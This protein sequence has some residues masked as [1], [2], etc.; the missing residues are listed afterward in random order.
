MLRVLVAV[1][2]KDTTNKEHENTTLNKSRVNRAESP[3]SS[4][5]LSFARLPAPVASGTFR[6]MVEG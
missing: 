2:W 3:A 5:A 6:G 4:T 1:F